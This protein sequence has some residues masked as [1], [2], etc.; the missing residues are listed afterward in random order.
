MPLNGVRAK[1]IRNAAFI[2]MLARML[3]ESWQEG[4]RDAK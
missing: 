1:S 3:A 2:R 4:V